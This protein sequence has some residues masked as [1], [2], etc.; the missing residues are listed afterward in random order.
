MDNAYDQRWAL[1][2]GEIP[3]DLRI[4][5]RKSFC[6]TKKNWGILVFSFIQNDFDLL[7]LLNT[8]KSG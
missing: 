4:V 2:N 5:A 1:Y 6:G 7:T 3:Q 8:N